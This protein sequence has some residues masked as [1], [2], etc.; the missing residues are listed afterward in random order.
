MPTRR[1]FAIGAAASV[2]AV[3][4]PSTSALATPVV[5]RGLKPITIVV[6]LPKNGPTDLVARFFAGPLSKALG[7]AVEISNISG[8]WGMTGAMVAAN[9]EA[10]GHTLI[11]GQV[12]THAALPLIIGRYD[13]VRDFT[14]V[15]LL[16]VSPM[17]VLARR[18]LG[19]SSLA[20]LKTLI[21]AEGPTL[22][23]ANGGIGSA[24]AIT[25]H[26]LKQAMGSPLLHEQYYA[27]TAPALDDLAQGRVDLL[28][29]QM[30]SALPAIRAGHVQAL[31][32][33]A[34]SRTHAMPDVFTG[35]Q[36]GFA[37]LRASNWHGLFAPK[38]LPHATQQRLAAAIHSVLEDVAVTRAMRERGLHV[39]FAEQR[40]PV[41][42]AVLQ[43][44]DI[45]ELATMF[46]GVA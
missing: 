27:G 38:G 43:K 36:Q 32:I 8:D 37:D 4:L 35:T 6:S 17:V 9:A 39:P 19:V 33:A 7:Q 30:I 42:L 1:Q 26:K 10:D 5:A 34:T 28:C 12:A 16:S 41:Q 22:K 25:A 20:E 18:D 2:A 46:G 14:P 11:M 15:G 44:K 29:D 31:G 23:L 24:S 21:S 45:A 13:A 40:G 3:A